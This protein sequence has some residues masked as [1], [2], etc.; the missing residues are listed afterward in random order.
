M[1]SDVFLILQTVMSN[2]WYLFISWR[3]PGLHATPGSLALFVLVVYVV[4][5]F[6]KR[7][8]GHD[9]SDK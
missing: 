5:K 9:G 8:A 1:S 2:C 7:I 6:L 4:L 3:L